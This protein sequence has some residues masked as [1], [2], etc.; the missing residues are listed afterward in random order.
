M[1]GILG[2]EPLLDGRHADDLGYVNSVDETYRLI[3][4]FEQ[5]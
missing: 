4:K 3:V 1:A 2:R 5:D